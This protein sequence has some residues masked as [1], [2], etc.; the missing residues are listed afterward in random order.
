M[1]KQSISQQIILDKAVELAQ[2]SSWESFSLRQLAISL[3]CDMNKVRRYFRSKDDM[4]EA[5]FDRA[6]EAMLQITS[7]ENYRS[8]SSDERLLECIMGWFES[9]LPY[10]GLIKEILA[11]KFE[12]GH[13]HL[14]AHG[15]T[16]VSR[17]VQWFLEA[18]E[19]KQSGLSRVIDEVAVTSAYL[20]SLSFF[21]FDKSAQHTNTRTLLKGLIRKIAQAEGLL[22]RS[23]HRQNFATG[24]ANNHNQASQ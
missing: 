24:K 13:F 9:L 11:Y 4:A 1:T 16:R 8:L 15:I 12:P 17:T 22:G 5:L 14:Q 10:K 23:T 2:K 18:A 20:V 6:D 19:R 3:D 7:Q 21:L